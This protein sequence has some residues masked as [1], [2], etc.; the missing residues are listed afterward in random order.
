MPLGMDAPCHSMVGSLNLKQTEQLLV[1]ESFLMFLWS[2]CILARKPLDIILAW[3]TKFVQQT[4]TDKRTTKSESRDLPGVVTTVS[5]ESVDETS[6]SS[7]GLNDLEFLLPPLPNDVM[8][9]DVW[10][11]LMVTTNPT[12]VFRFGWIN[13]RWRDFVRSTFEWQVLQFMQLDKI[14]FR[15]S[16]HALGL[17]QRPLSD[18]FR[19]TMANLCVL[20]TE[21]LTSFRPGRRSIP[22]YVSLTDCPSNLEVYLEYYDL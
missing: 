10:H 11:Q 15:A 14:G 22:S 3:I 2:F 21:N 12:L 9:R 1:W 4:V 5:S 20:L 16:I 7:I 19:A 18:W 17:R 8:S 6:P 13:H